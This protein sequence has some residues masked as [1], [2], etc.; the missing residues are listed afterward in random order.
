[1]LK[2]TL[3]ALALVACV[4][5]AAQPAV[6]GFYENW[7]TGYTTEGQALNSPWI[8]ASDGSM[9]QNR[10]MI[11]TQTSAYS[12]G[13]AVTNTAGADYIRGVASRPTGVVSTDTDLV[14]MWTLRAASGSGYARFAL[15]PFAGAYTTD[16]WQHI[17][18]HGSIEVNVPGDGRI[19]IMYMPSTGVQD[20]QDVYFDSLPT[21]DWI[22]VRVTTPNASG[23]GQSAIVDWKP[24][25]SGSW[26]AVG[27]PI[28]LDAAYNPIH[29]G[30][31][32]TYP[33]GAQW[34]FDDVSV[35]SVP[36]PVT[37]LTLSLGLLAAALR[38]RRS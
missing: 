11:A 32:A 7:D 19:V 25:S 38:R 26:T 9:Y 33:V 17:S 35:S 36:E 21:T 4:A 12:D 30:I 34:W 37:L 3:I 8:D 31:G 15:S 20:R 28:A 23:G 22:T 2:K 24:A 29:C 14:A 16:G 27:D 18:M 6:A 5:I 10:P 1:M 13:W